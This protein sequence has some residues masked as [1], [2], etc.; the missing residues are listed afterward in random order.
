MAREG[1]LGRGFLIRREGLDAARS[2]V[3]V[4]APV[5]LKLTTYNGDRETVGRVVGLRHGVWSIALETYLSP[6]QASLTVYHELAHV[7]E[8]QRVGGFDA[9]LNLQE[10]ELRRARVIGRGQRKHLRRWAIARTP[11]EREA[12]RLAHAWHREHHLATPR[13]KSWA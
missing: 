5:E 8:A 3:G 12:E 13:R 4:K 11:L 7:L 6:R 2:R 9:L 1:W 10:D